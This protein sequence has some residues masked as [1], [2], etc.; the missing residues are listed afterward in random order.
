MSGSLTIVD[1]PS[2]SGKSVYINEVAVQKRRLGKIMIVCRADQIYDSFLACIKKRH[3]SENDSYTPIR[4]DTMLSPADIY[5][6]EDIDVFLRGKEATQLEFANI[7]ARTI[8]QGK[9]IYITGID[10]KN[11]VGT[12]WEAVEKRC[13]NI[14]FFEFIPPSDT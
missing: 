9:D 5:A 3:M 11:R 4:L 13:L 14:R 10:L 1:A 8:S 7:I 6:L 12:F 2:G